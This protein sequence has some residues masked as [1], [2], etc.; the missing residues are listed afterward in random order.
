MIMV[1]FFSITFFWYNKSMQNYIDKLNQKEIQKN[2]SSFYKIKVVDSISS[3]NSW[4]SDHTDLS[5]GYVLIADHQTDG[6]GRNG[7]TFYSPA[8]SGIYLSLLLKPEEDKECVLHYTALSALCMCEAIESVYGFSPSIKWLNDIY[9]HDKKIGGILC[10]GKLQQDRF[11]S[12]IIGIGIN[13][14]SFIYPEDISSIACTVEDFMPFKK[15][16]NI[17]ITRFLE[18]FYN[19]YT[20]HHSFLQAYKNHLAYVNQSVRIIHPKKEY[21]GTI[22][23]VDDSFRLVI[24]KEDGLIDHLS[25]GEISIRL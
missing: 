13:V 1:H 22:L 25:S 4:L 3:T 6:K 23:G 12:L 11:D 8:N 19:Y 15:P 2:L 20:N 14:H 9:F 17:L 24:K 5:E 16:R 21:K 18:S 10:E 7:R